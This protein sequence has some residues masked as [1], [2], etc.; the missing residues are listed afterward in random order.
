MNLKETRN[1][2]DEPAA[3]YDDDSIGAAVDMAFDNVLSALKEL[4]EIIK[5]L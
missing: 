5:R 4:R 1:K 2:N 3:E